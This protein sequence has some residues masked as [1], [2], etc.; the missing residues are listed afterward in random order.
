MSFGCTDG[1]QFVSTFCPSP[2]ITR[3]SMAVMLARDLAGGDA[4]VPSR[5]SDAGNGRAYDC[6]DGKGNAFTDVP[7]SDADCKYIYF[8]WSRK[9]VDG[10]GD[11]TY[12]PEDSVSREQMAKYLTNA[13]QLSLQ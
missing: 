6:T 9:V 7:D 13:Y 11:G 3:R 5:L 2:A 8:I 1:N 12:G 4:Q 10:F